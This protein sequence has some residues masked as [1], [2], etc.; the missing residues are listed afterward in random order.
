MQTLRSIFDFIFSRAT[1]AFIG[2][3]VLALAIWF[4][5]PLLAVDGLRPLASVGVRVGLLVLLLV[6]AILRL[7]SAP[8]SLAG[9]AALCLLTWHAGPLLSLGAA[10]PLAPVWVRATVIGVIL[11]ACATYWL[12]KLWQAVKADPDAIANFFTAKSEQDKR[13]NETREQLKD[14]TGSVQRAMARL[15]N[16]RG[17]GGLRRIIEGK[18]YLYDLPWYM[19]VGSPDAGKTTALLNSGLQ[20]PLARKMGG[21]A[22]SAAF[23][24]NGGTMHCD[25]W[26]S[27]EAVLIDTAG[28]YT[29]QSSNAANDAIEWRG[30]L[31]L[32][33]KHRT[34]APIN[35]AIVALNTAAGRAP[36]RP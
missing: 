22:G 8:I 31:G 14:V 32:L 33:R 25:W 1:L 34:R 23:A 20:F 26:L 17:S 3:V 28:R 9:V 16:L 4:V 6:F 18:R 12:Y 5:G 10:R 36:R 30:F 29:T 35:G 13:K 27:N 7:A 11:M 15:K 2:L 24:A 19:I 21:P